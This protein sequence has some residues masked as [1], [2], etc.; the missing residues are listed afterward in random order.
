MDDHWVIRPASADDAPAIVAAE[1]ACFTDPWSEA[2][3]RELFGNKTVIGLIADLSGLESLLAGYLFLRAIG[4]EAEILNLAVIPDLRGRGIGGA[5]LDRGLELV[6]D[7][8]AG[9]VFLEVRESNEAAKRL[10]RARGFEAVGFRADYYR[11]PR[12]HALVLRRRLGT[13]VI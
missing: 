12:E 11:R 5:L 1:R 7:R 13:V 2:A 3:I 9:S 4:G 10:Y 6:A 8:G